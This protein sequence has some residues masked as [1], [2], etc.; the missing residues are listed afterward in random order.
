[1]KYFLLS[2]IILLGLSHISAGIEHESVL[3]EYA[4][5][6]VI[7][8]S[9]RQLVLR[10]YDV[11]EDKVVENTYQ[12]SPNAKFEN[13]DSVEALSVGDDIDVDYVI[14]NESKKI[15]FIAVD[16]TLQILKKMSQE[17]NAGAS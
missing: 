2:L 3:P 12:I 4:Y 11:R 1:M 17:P 16:K 10:E 8:I 7:Q 15:V 6:T 9:K 5:G 13:V 14:D